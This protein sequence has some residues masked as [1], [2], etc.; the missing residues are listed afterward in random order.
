MNEKW[1]REKY[2]KQYNIVAVAD[3]GDLTSEIAK[4]Y[5][6]LYGAY[7]KKFGPLDRIIIYSSYYLGGQ[8]IENLCDAAKVI[9]ISPNFILI[10]GNIENN[11]LVKDFFKFENSWNSF[12]FV[13]DNEILN[14]KPI[15][16]YALNR[17]SL[18]PLPWSHLEVTNNGDIKPCCINSMVLGNISKNNINDIFTG[19]NINHI[20]EEMI[21]GIKPQSCHKCWKT[22]D[23]GLTS[24]RIRHLKFYRKNFFGKYLHSPKISSLDI[25]PGNLCNFKCRICSSE[26]SSSHMKE[27]NSIRITPLTPS[28][29]ESNSSLLKNDIIDLQE[30]LENLDFYGGE[31]FLVKPLTKV[32]KK[33]SKMPNAKN[34]RLHY[35]TNG[36]VFPEFLFDYFSKFKEVNIMFSIDDIGKR[37]E[38]QRGGSWKNVDENI[39][40]FC[41]LHMKNLDL[42]IMP[43]INI[44][45]CLYLDELM[46]WAEEKNINVFFNYL[47]KPAGYA[48]NQLTKKAKQ[49]LFKKYNNTKYTEIKNL[50]QHIN[51]LPDSDGREFLKITKYYDSIRNENFYKSHQEI[52]DLMIPHKHNH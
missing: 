11:E 48:L 9:D 52:F 30:N 46:V 7:K 8:F 47:S 5:Q 16:A 26:A 39:T 33:L 17:D 23:A 12:E 19:D 35:N 36:S 44:M 31:P 29:W 6:F 10:C 21:S 25:K 32:V 41:N 15:N 22:E 3:A 13:H 50:M 14:T 38:I 28:T 20:R 27:Q 18:C 37:F 42:G 43:T 40:K 24:N 49:S 45:N 51:D 34:I 4:E 2:K 1:I